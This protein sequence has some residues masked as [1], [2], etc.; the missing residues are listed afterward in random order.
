MNRRYSTEIS[1]YD[2][3]QIS[4]RQL[5]RM[6]ILETGTI[7][8]LMV[9]LWSGRENGLLT[10]LI[11]I[12]I[13]LLYGGILIAIGRS[14]GGF[15][16][17]TERTFPHLIWRGI[18]ILYSLR[19][20]L[21]AAWILSYLVHLIHETLYDHA[22]WLILLP[23][24]IVCIYAGDRTLPERA[25]FAELIFLWVILPLCIIFLIGIWK[26]DLSIPSDIRTPMLPQLVRDGYR[27]S[28]LFLPVEFL[29]FRMS[30]LRENTGTIWRSSFFSIVLSGL[31]MTLVY[32]V[33]IGILGNRWGHSNLLGVT[34]AM[35]QII[36]WNGAFERMDILILLFWLIGSIYAFSSYLFQGQQLLKRAFSLGEISGSYSGSLIF[37]LIEAGLIIAIYP[38][39]SSVEEWNRWFIS[40]A[41]YI[42]IPL[43]IGIPVIIWCCFRIRSNRHVHPVNPDIQIQGSAIKDFSKNQKMAVR[44]F[45]KFPDR[46]GI[47][48]IKALLLPIVL[49]LVCSSFSGCTGTDSIEDRA[50]VKELHI[51]S[52]KGPY[53]FLCVLS[54]ISEESASMLDDAMDSYSASAESIQEYNDDFQK[55]TDCSFDY[56]HLQGIYLDQELYNP[57]QCGQ[58]LQEIRASTKAVL[59]TP[60]YY[61]NARIGDQQEITLGDWLK[62]NKEHS[63]E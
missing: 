26:T 45:T 27:L 41:C 17:I 39:F 61:E 60:I 51:S 29:L 18:W 12:L 34:D 52:S 58:L 44:D 35:E 22:P 9:P 16:A 49:L 21:H 24:I 63:P 15:Y 28:A 56:S 59:S 1:S 7:S 10:I 53:E 50:Y 8:C 55:L 33:T 47:Q 46:T 2:P 38:I 30:A 37:T 6:S 43:S 3:Y 23:L 42:D 4:I 25:R 19:Y 57:T 5:I 32:V 48:R 40:Y 14:G 20:A 54:Y 31:W 11:S 13:S 62:Y 36:K